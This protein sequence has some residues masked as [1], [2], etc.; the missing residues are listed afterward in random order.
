VNHALVLPSL[1]VWEGANRC[2]RGSYR[3]DP[4]AG[5]VLWD[6]SFGMIKSDFETPSRESTKKTASSLA[7]RRVLDVKGKERAVFQKKINSCDVVGCSGRCGA[8]GER[9]RGNACRAPSD[10][11]P[12]LGEFL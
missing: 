10:A 9:G 1:R 7:I 6:W 3:P 5:L 8:R 12:L 11:V 4:V 2:L